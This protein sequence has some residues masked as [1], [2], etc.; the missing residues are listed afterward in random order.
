[1]LPGRTA[2]THMYEGAPSGAAID[3]NG[4]HQAPAYLSIRGLEVHFGG[5]RTV[6]PLALDVNAG[7]F[8][9]LLGPS[10][11]GKTT[12]LRCVAGI[13]R[14]AA[15]VISIGGV[16]TTSVADGIDVSPERRDVG[17]V[18]Q[19]YALWPHLKVRENI[20]FP[21]R[22]RKLSRSDI[23]RKVQDILERVGLASLGERLPSELS[24]GQQ[25]RIALARALVYQPKLLLM[26]EPLS[27]LDTSIRQAVRADIRRLQQESH[28][29]TLYVTHDQEEAIALSDRIAVMDHGVM[30][31]VGTPDELISMPTSRLVASMLGPANFIQA[32]VIR[33]LSERQ[34]L[35]ELSM[36]SLVMAVPTAEPVRADQVVTVCVRP[37]DVVIQSN[38][39]ASQGATAS[40]IVRRIRPGPFAVE[41]TLEV[42]STLIHAAGQADLDLHVG[43]T[44]RFRFAQGVAVSS[45]GTQAGQPTLEIDGGN[46]ENGG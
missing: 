3:R 8:V 24:G 17:M 25:Q 2:E 12:T 41:Y 19:S 11:C 29:T 40:A 33:T 4:L 34:V 1:M 13:T 14:P 21:L 31:Q 16:V 43:D 9:T 44:A 7:E 35:V 27:N 28:I 6:G 42:A 26:D 46:L 23:D 22:L 45:M 38:L 39:L 20:A 37:R 15:G 10:G 30:L 36:A 18:F 32:R 5:R